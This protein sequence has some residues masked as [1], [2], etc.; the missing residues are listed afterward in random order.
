RHPDANQFYRDHYRTYWTSGQTSHPAAAAVMQAELSH[1][2]DLAGGD[3]DSIYGAG[4]ARIA[5]V[6][7]TFQAA[8]WTGMYY[9]DHSHLVNSGYFLSALILYRTIYQDNVSDIDLNT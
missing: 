4:T 8:N 9:T 6:G 7:D 2:Y 1:A 3:I 5:P